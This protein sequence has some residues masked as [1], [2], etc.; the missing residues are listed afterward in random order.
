[1]CAS[2]PHRGCAS[3]GVRRDL[4]FRG[5]RVHART[6]RRCS[7]PGLRGANY[8]RARQRALRLAHAPQVRAGYELAHAT[9]SAGP[10]ARRR[11]TKSAPPDTACREACRRGARNDG[12]Q[13]GDRGGSGAA[14][15]SRRPG[16]AIR[17]CRI[18]VRSACLRAAVPA[19]EADNDPVAGRRTVHAVASRTP[20]TPCRVRRCTRACARRSRSS[21][22]SCCGQAGTRAAHPGRRPARAARSSRSGSRRNT[23]GHRS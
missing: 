7:W 1:V 16:S 20:R 12:T 2:A 23:P 22:R 21:P 15:H 6:S 8:L 3:G 4:M 9:P 11:C 19:R 18:H 17:R 14:T 10:G 5:S 13:A